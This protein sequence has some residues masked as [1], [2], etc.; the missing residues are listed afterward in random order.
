MSATFGRDRESRPLRPPPLALDGG[1]F[2]VSRA[3]ERARAPRDGRVL[4][5]EPVSKRLVVEDLLD[6]IPVLRCSESSQSTSR[7]VSTT[8]ILK[9]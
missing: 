9:F 6:P 5:R 4:E 7:R 3:D 1:G 8:L 2:H